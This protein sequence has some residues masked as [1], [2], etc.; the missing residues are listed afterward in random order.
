MPVIAREFWL[1]NNSSTDTFN[2]DGGLSVNGIIDGN[3]RDLKIKFGI[4]NIPIE[5]LICIGCLRCIK[6]LLKLDSL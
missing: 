1:K 4:D 6:I 3:I 2:N 5:N